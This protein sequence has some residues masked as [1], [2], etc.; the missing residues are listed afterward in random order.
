MRRNEGYR[1]ACEQ[2]G[3]GRHSK[4]YADFGDV[5]SVDFKT[6]WTTGDRG[7]RLF[8]EPAAPLTV[9]KLSQ[10][11][12]VSLPPNWDQTSLMIVAVPLTFS[13]RFIEQQFAKILR[14]NH[15]RRRGERML[16]ASRALYPIHTQFNM[17]SLTTALQVYDMR[18]SQPNMTLWEIAQELKFT[19]TLSPEELA[20]KGGK[21]VAVNKKAVMSAVVSRKLKQAGKIIEGV[22]KG[23]FP[24]D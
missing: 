19:T 18:S 12:L 22:G 6:W 24:A 10:S 4:L 1:L 13:K 23:I 20:G 11:D 5:F 8:A 17:S 7:A 14:T 15:T 3:A 21:A 2:A 16:K 9:S